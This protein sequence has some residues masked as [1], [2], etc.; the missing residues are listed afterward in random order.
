MRTKPGEGEGAE[1][2]TGIHWDILGIKTW[3]PDDKCSGYFALH[4]Q[5][6]LSFGSS[7][8]GGG[9]RLRA[10][11]LLKYSIYLPWERQHSPALTSQTHRASFEDP[12]RDSWGKGVGGS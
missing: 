3:I 7:G 9:T 11:S 12:F 4:L 2:S 1:L 5:H 6:P 10:D 8:G